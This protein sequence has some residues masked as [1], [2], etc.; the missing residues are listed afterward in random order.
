[1]TDFKKTGYFGNYKTQK[2]TK[3]G[4]KT[5]LKYH[6]NIYTKSYSVNFLYFLFICPVFNFYKISKKYEKTFYSIVMW[7]SW[8]VV[9]VTHFP[10]M[11]YDLS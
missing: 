8:A 3:S 11:T 6:I 7:G 5:E 10:F 2:P 9:G 4:S 1:M